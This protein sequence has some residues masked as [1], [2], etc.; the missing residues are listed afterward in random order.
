MRHQGRNRHGGQDA[1][2]DPSENELPQT[3]M[4]VTSHH[5]EIGGSVGGM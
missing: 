1:A 5:Q 3:R 2:S 4:A